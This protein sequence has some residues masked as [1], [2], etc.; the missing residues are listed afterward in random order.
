MY[1]ITSLWY[2]QRFDG[3]RADCWSRQEPEDDAGTSF[4]E[5]HGNSGNVSIF[6]YFYMYLPQN[7]SFI[8]SLIFTNK[9]DF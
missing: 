2:R 6:P 9:I 4:S 3:K 1:G 5:Q 7:H 8:K